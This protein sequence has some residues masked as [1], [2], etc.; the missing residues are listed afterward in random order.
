M[1]VFSFTWTLQQEYWLEFWFHVSGSLG[2]VWHIEWWEVLP[3][4]RRVWNDMIICTNINLESLVL[5]SI[6]YRNSRTQCGIYRNYG[7]VSAKTHLNCFCKRPMIVE[8]NI[9]F[10]LQGQ[11]VS[12]PSNCFFSKTKVYC[13]FCCAC[14]NAFGHT[15]AISYVRWSRILGGF[16]NNFQLLGIE[17]KSNWL[18][19][20]W[21]RH[22]FVNFSQKLNGRQ[23]VGQENKQWQGTNRKS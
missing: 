14:S 12:I 9:K 11:E 22:C 3:F 8:L 1:K 15:V 13:P 20:L 2:E 17:N 4:R 18:F 19:V 10:Y 7:E 21:K 23:I 6:I 5:Q 16:C